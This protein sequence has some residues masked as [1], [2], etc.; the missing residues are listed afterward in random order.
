MIRWEREDSK[1]YV[2]SGDNEWGY[3]EKIEFMT[4]F[5]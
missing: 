3:R 4:Y 2:Q 1:L 5:S